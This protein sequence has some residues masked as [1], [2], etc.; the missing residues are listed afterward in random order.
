M[1][2]KLTQVFKEKD[3]QRR[4]QV[5]ITYED[6]MLMVSNVSN[7]YTEFAAKAK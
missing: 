7:K 5:T 2:Q 3:T 6:F 1:L 4:G